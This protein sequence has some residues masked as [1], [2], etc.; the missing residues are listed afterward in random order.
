MASSV[1]ELFIFHP[2][3]FIWTSINHFISSEYMEK[4][5]LELHTRPAGTPGDA[6]LPPLAPPPPIHDRD[7]HKRMSH[8]ILS[9]IILY[10]FLL[11]ILNE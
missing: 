6:I 9:L 3:L 2:P 4:Q 7:R 11:S 5:I 10:A 1:F 8:M